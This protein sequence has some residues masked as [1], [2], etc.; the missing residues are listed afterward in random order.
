MHRSKQFFYS[1]TSSAV[2]SSNRGTVRPSTGGLEA[3]RQ[4]EFD[5]GLPATQGEVTALVG[6]LPRGHALTKS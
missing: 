5:Q 3:D 1:I 6:M 2:A 4:F